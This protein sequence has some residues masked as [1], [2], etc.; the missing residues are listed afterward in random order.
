MLAGSEADEPLVIESVVDEESRWPLSPP[1]QE[2]VC[3]RHGDQYVLMAIGRAGRSHW[4][5][6]WRIVRESGGEEI[7]AEIACRIHDPADF[8]GSTFR[9][10]GRPKVVSAAGDRIAIVGNVATITFHTDLRHAHVQKTSDSL[11]S[12]QPVLAL[13]SP[14]PDTVSYRYR[15]VV[16]P[17]S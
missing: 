13:P 9:V 11:F 2:A 14:V 7:E 1:W 15:I 17:N 12:I 16:H 6:C 8:L 3:E 5:G 4:S 10:A